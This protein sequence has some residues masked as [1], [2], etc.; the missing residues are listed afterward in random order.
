MRASSSS[1]AST[2][3]SGM[4]GG[5]ALIHSQHRMAVPEIRHPR[6]VPWS[7]IG[8]SPLTA[9]NPH[10]GSSVWDF[11]LYDYAPLVLETEARRYPPMADITGLL[12][13]TTVSHR[14]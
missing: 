3:S 6:S 13:S 7:R 1:T 14:C 11:W 9:P 12:D 4:P 2:R 5:Q 8:A 10:A